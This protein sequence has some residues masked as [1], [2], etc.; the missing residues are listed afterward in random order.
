SVRGAR[1]NPC[2]YRDHYGQ[3]GQSGGST[4]SI[5]SIESIKSIKS[6]RS[7]Y[8]EIAANA[9]LVLIGVASALLDRQLASLAKSFEAEGGFTERL[10]RVRSK[11]RNQE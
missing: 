3:H 10:Y 2:P 4:S 5:E 8:P 1:G 7:T 6:I 9:A 11:K